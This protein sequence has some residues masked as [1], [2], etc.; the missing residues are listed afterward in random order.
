MRI[1]V[2]DGVELWFEVLGAKRVPAAGGMRDRPTVVSVHG[3]PGSDSANDLEVLA[4]ISDYAQLV[5]FD[6]RGHCRSTYGSAGDWTLDTWADDIVRLCRVLG[7]ERPVVIGGSF[8][9]FVVQRYA[10]RHPDHAAGIGLYVTAPR[11]DEAAIVER[12][13]EPGGDVAAE[14][15][16]AD[17]E[18]STS[19]TSEAFVQHCLPL[20]TARPDAHAWFAERAG[21]GIDTPEVN[22]HFTNPE[23]KTMDQRQALAMLRSPALLLLGELDPMIPTSLGLEVEACAPAGL[24]ESHVVADAGHLLFRDQPELT[25]RLL[26]SF[27]LRLADQVSPAP[28]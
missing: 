24:V 15:M 4:P 11:M 14:V 22:L 25:H 13:R 5:V 12:F 18:R 20:M 9:G 16:R 17:F 26:G 6:Q 2:D 27:V 19:A 21:R 10:T 1:Q 3:G 28:D 23:A 8:G 7:I